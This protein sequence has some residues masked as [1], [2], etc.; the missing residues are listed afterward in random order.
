MA[1]SAITPEE[2]IRKLQYNMV[3]DTSYSEGE[4]IIKDRF[5]TKKSE[6]T[7]YARGSQKAI[8]EFTN[9]EE[10]GQKILRLKDEIYLFYPDA[11]EIIR[12]QGRALRDSILGSDISYED[13][14][15]PRDL[16]ESYS[17]F[18]EGTEEIDGKPCYKVVLKAKK[19]NL[20][21]S[22]QIAWVDAEFFISR[23]VHLFSLSDRLLKIIRSS[24]IRRHESGK[25]IQYSLKVSD[26]MK[27]DSVTELILKKLKVN[28][29][30]SPDTFSLKELTW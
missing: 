12:I 30:L 29:A 11:E 14:L 28:I 18:L 17:V 26:Q 1:L 10:R 13:I 3:H 8:F 2:I 5:G 16:L 4:I 22:K 21:Y 25:N 6:Y 15:G 9:V 7:L 27:R 20:P 24:D 23:Q 19:K